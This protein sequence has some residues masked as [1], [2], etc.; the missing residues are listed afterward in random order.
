MGNLSPLKYVYSLTSH[1]RLKFSGEIRQKQSLQSLRIF[2]LKVYLV[3]GLKAHGLEKKW[4]LDM[5]KVY[6][7]QCLLWLDP[8]DSGS[9]PL[10]HVPFFSGDT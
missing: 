4:K 5:L 6:F 1:S 2:T 7:L 8:F 10:S 9:E 3:I